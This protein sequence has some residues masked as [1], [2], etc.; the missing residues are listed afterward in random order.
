[1]YLDIGNDIILSWD[2]ITII[3]TSKTA[4]MDEKVKGLISQGKIE[5]PIQDKSIHSYIF[6][7]KE[8]KEKLYI[9]SFTTETLLKRFLL[10]RINDDRT[11]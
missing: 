3:L 7:Q 1:M 9:S 5:N 8:D 10:E 6:V 11:K 4:E 2:E